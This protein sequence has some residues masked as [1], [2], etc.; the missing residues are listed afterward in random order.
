MRSDGSKIDVGAKTINIVDNGAPPGTRIELSGEAV[1]ALPNVTTVTFTPVTLDG[2]GD[3]PPAPDTSR[4]RIGGSNAVAVDI[5]IS[6]SVDGNEVTVCLPITSALLASLGNDASSVKMLHYDENNNEWVEIDTTINT[7]SDGVATEACA[8]TTS[9]SV[10]ALAGA[11]ISTSVTTDTP[12]PVATNTPSNPD[13]EIPSTLIDGDGNQYEVFTPEEGGNFDGDAFS[14]T[15]TR[16]AVQNG[17]YIGVRMY[18]SD[19][20]SNTG[21]THQRYTLGG[22]QYR[23]D[24]VDP[25]IDVADS[26]GASVMPY[27]L[28]TPAEVCMPLPP[29]LNASINDATILT[30]NPDGTLA[31]ISSSVRVGTSGTQICG[32]ISELPALIAVG[33]QGTPAA[34]P[35]PTPEPTP[36]A[37]E[38]GGASPSAAAILWLILLGAA[39]ATLSVFVVKRR[40]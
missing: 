26:E 27:R 31:V 4:Y 19:A 33:K 28:N 24:V 10:F 21:E 37:P 9:F 11:A 20:A 22:N 6:A 39:V 16:G 15:A 13:G 34:I 14:I 36:E 40:V 17:E 2:T 18:E 25:G 3:N 38:T 30:T 32:D 8:T 5:T 7:D 23:I 35:A 29:E 1:D 12:T